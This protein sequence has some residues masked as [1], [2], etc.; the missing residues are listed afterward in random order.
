MTSATTITKTVFLAAPRTTVWTFLTDKDR[1]GTWFYPATADLALGQDYVLMQT[2]ADGKPVRQCWGRV[3]EL[4]PPSTLKYTFTIKP[5]NGV[6]TTV[7]WRLEEVLGGTQLTLVHEGIG[8]MGDAALG[9]LT[10]LD[11]GWDRHLGNLRG[12]CSSKT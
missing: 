2:P 5:L 11:A 9:L 4:E 12:A 6:M 1:L 7:S 10:A 3:L 8:E